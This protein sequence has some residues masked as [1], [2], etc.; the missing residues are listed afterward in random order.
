MLLNEKGE[1]SKGLEILLKQLF[2][3]LGIDGNSTIA[4]ISGIHELLKRHIAQQDEML[5]ALKRIENGQPN[6]SANPVIGQSA[7]VG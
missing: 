3:M 5:A 6:V 1:L 7:D 4:Q 2:K